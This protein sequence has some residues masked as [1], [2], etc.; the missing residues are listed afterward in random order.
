LRHL[1]QKLPE[2]LQI[3]LNPTTPYNIKEEIN[4]GDRLDQTTA[5]LQIHGTGE[6]LPDSMAGG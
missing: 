2:N 4:A 6:A 5:L 3:W 1:A